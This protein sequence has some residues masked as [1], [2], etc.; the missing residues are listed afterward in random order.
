MKKRGVAD[1]ELFKRKTDVPQP[2]ADG[3]TDY[4]QYFMTRKEKIM[5]IA[6]AAAALFAIGYIFYHSVFLSALLMLLAVKF[7]AIRTQQIIKKRK[8]ELTLQFKDML[9]SLSSSLSAGRS[10]ESALHEALNDLKIIYNDENTDILKEL[11]YIV[12]GIEMNE[13][14][15]SMFTQFSERAHI[16]DIENFTDIFK[17]CKRTGGDLVQ[18]I[19]STSQTIGDKIEIKQEIETLISGKKF[20]FKILMVM[21]VALIVLLSA[22][23]YDY[24]QPVFETFIG[25]LVMTVTIAIFA[26]AYFI[27]GKIMDIKV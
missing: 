4:N 16:E 18:V 17:T 9:Y 12:R 3:L 26:A 6:M 19:K 24:M 15:E 1:V 25:H 13:T 5:Y 20:E 8:A 10:I 21:P 2:R 7:P 11:E 27:G 23:A 14:V 22:T